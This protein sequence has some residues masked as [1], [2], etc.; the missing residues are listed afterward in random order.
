MKL[1]SRRTRQVRTTLLKTGIWIFLAAFL[2]S[3]VGVA[4]VISK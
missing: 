2:F 3:I 1:E 4:I